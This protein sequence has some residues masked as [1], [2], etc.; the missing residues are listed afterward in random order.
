MDG[1]RPR[2]FRRDSESR[3]LL[4]SD[5][6]RPTSE[7]EGHGFMFYQSET[8]DSEAWD[9]SQPTFISSHRAAFNKDQDL[10]STFV[11]KK[12]PIVDSTMSKMLLRRINKLSHKSN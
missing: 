2:L 11:P 5:V 12:P 10:Y 3:P 7:S 1:Y 6:S 8:S 4:S 9:Q